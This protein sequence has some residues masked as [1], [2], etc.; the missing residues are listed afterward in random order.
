LGYFLVL[1]NGIMGISKHY[2]PNL[3]YLMY[4]TEM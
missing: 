3:R 2:E 1:M 4:I